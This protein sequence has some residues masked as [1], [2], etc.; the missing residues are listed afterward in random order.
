[1]KL[2]KKIYKYIIA[3]VLGIALTIGFQ[4]AYA[5]IVSSSD[6]VT[7]TPSNTTWNV[8]NV[9]S[10][11]NSLYQDALNNYTRGYNDGQAA[12][13]NLTLYTLSAH[14]SYYDYEHG[15]DRTVCNQYTLTKNG[16]VIFS[17]HKGAEGG[18]DMEYTGYINGTV[19][20]SNG[21]TSNIL[22]VSSGNAVK[23]CITYRSGYAA[24]TINANILY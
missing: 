5:A 3:L 4:Y 20:F 6:K 1:M 23:V 24:G 7:F 2:I 22:S 12:G 8:N 19:K 18:N 14:N 21:N 13:A 9:E 11:L 17:F 16:Y 10:A 15:G